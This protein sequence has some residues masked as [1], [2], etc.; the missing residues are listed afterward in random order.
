MDLQSAEKTAS[1][2]GGSKGIG[3]GIADALAAEGVA[4]AILARN[5]ETL[6]R[7]FPK[8]NREAAARMAFAAT[9]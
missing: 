5:R 9:R 3:R 8:S 1:F 7:R 6:D 2:S 4:V